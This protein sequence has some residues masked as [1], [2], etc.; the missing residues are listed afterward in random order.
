M[1][2]FISKD[3]NY[4]Q[5]SVVGGKSGHVLTEKEINPINSKLLNFDV[6]NFEKDIVTICNSPTRGGTIAG[7]LILEGNKTY[8]KIGKKFLYKCIPDDRRLPIF[9]VTYKI[10]MTFDKAQKNRYVIIHFRNWNDKHP[11]GYI[12][13]NL[14][15]VTNLSSFYQ[16]QLYCRSL[17]ASIQKF[18]KTTRRELKKYSETEIVN[19]IIT[20]YNVVDRRKMVGIIT[21]D[22]LSS[23]D[24]DDAFGICST[25]QGYIL[26]IYIAN[27]PLWLD[28]LG[29]WS[30]FSN[31]VSTIYLPDR[32]LPM[33]PTILSDTL[34]SLKEGCSRFALA[35]DIHLDKSYK[36]L[37]YEFTNTVIRV[38]TNLRYDTKLMKTNTTYKQVFDIVNTL[39][40]DQP[41]LDNIKSCH[42]MVAYLMIA[43]NH[44][45]AEY[46][47]KNKIGIYRSMTFGNTESPP[48]LGDKNILNF[49]KGWH[50]SGGKYTNF[51]DMVKH[52]ALA[53]DRY[54]HITSPIRRLVDLIN[55][56]ELQSNTN[57]AVLSPGAKNFHIKW[58]TVSSLTFINETMRSIR[59]VQ[60]ECTLLHLCTT[61]PDILSRNHR[62]F[63]F[64][65]MKRTDGMF[66][67]QVYL[68]A[69]KMVRKTITSLDLMINIYADFEL[70][71]FMDQ[72]RLYKKVRI[73]LSTDQ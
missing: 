52:D 41:Y 49:L 42:D 2:R 20:H 16:Y 14:G 39:Y 24:F 18:T 44:Y 68:T 36:I 33:M 10:K 56:I 4:Q 32:K 11:I 57:I 51:E 54:L 60:N 5:W 59:K 38:S 19:N 40:K 34:C 55:M 47:F 6:F 45:C 50:G 66:Q 15:A 26:S 30:S 73:T 25:T 29:L 35:L 69:L 46:M 62:G 3:R 65:K 12:D 21:I 37:K 28:F 70:Y 9:L 8:G 71:L 22:P 31:R 27:V 61:T 1:Y 13:Q 17:N 63:I 58:T 67:Y 7:V 48:A 53:L 23:K 43:M 64:D 72:D